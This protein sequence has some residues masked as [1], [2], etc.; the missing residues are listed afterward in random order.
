MKK[1][2]QYIFLK[3]IFGI[4]SVLILGITLY[5]RAGLNKDEIQKITGRI[6]YLEKTYGSYP[7]AREM[8]KCRYIKL[9]N[10]ADVFE[11]FIGKDRGDFTPDLEKMDS[12]R[13]GDEITI[14]FDNQVGPQD[15]NINA[16][17]RFIDK[18][19]EVV[20]IRGTWMKAIAGA[21]LGIAMIALM[22]VCILKVKGKL[23]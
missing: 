10:Y 19:N 21:V 8:G 16:A 4:S 3:S 6:A 1:D 7:L 14:Y 18:G 11:I 9:D 17:V 22:L 2:P 12:L 15:N 13:A 20:F 5:L 23:V